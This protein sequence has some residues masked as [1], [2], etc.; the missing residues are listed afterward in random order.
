MF[1]HSSS[2]FRASAQ[3]ACRRRNKGQKGASLVEYGL[4]VGFIF[5]P[6]LLGVG[7]FAHGLFVYHHLNN[8]AKEATRYAAVRGSTCSDDKS[9][10]ATNSAS[11]IVGATTS[12]DVKKFVQ[13]ITPTGIDASKLTVTVCGV[14]D[15]A[16]CPMVDSKGNR[17]DPAFCTADIKDKGGNIVQ[18][19]TPYH[20]GC[21][22][23]VQVQYTLNFIFPLIRPTSINM[24]STSDMVIVH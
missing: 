2:S 6:L 12:A 13:T 14:S 17:L 23:Q 19:K 22:V 21:T 8:A 3:T 11:G 1:I 9:C 15:T 18:A 10:L 7:G 24:S 16:V 5:L 20:P 4:I